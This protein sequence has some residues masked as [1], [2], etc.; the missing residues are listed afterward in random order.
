MIHLL[1]NLPTEYDL[2]L[3][4]SEERIGDKDK[5]LIFEEIRAEIMKN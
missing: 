4:L 3:A 5:L 1:N 2:Q